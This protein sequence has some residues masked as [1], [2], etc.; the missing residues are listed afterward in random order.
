MAAEGAEMASAAEAKAAPVAEA[1]ALARAVAG[2]EAVAVEAVA[3]AI[4]AV[5][6]AAADVEAAALADGAVLAG[7][8]AEAQA[9][10]LAAERAQEF[11]NVA[12]EV[13]EAAVE[14]GAGGEE[15]VPAVDILIP[16]VA[17]APRRG[18]GGEQPIWRHWI[19]RVTC[20]AVG[21]ASIAMVAVT[22][23]CLP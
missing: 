10:P 13:L 18:G 23:R 17:R 1:A 15:V 3:V 19:A 9:A 12:A 4:D 5:P 21:V 6:V 20:I 2:R 8:A 7:T 11:A 22:D 16:A 14:E